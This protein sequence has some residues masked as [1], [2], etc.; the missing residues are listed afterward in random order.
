MKK[1]VPV[2]LAF[3]AISIALGVGVMSDSDAGQAPPPH[4]LHFVAPPTPPC[5]TIFFVQVGQPVSFPVVLMP[6]N[7]ADTAGMRGPGP[8]VPGAT[9][10]PPT[11][12]LGNPVVSTFT[13]TPVAEG[14]YAAHYIG[15]LVGYP[16]RAFCN[17]SFEV[18]PPAGPH[19]SYTQGGWGATPH[20]HNAASILANNFATVY[21]SGVEVGILGTGGFS[22]IFTSANAV[23]NYLPAGGTPGALDADSANPA[24][25]NH[26]GVFGGQVLAL[27]INVDFSAAGVTQNGGGAFGSVRICSSGNLELDGSTVAQVLQAANTALGGGPLPYGLAWISELND[28]VT[29]L[30]ESFDNCQTSNWGSLHLC[31]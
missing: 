18:L 2:S 14:S 28:L 7:P 24:S 13:W 20:G 3:F 26:S 23:K 22:M 21:P 4:T 15:A 25:D 19:C 1:I 16:A 30:N 6:D 12:L 5:G 29:A 11:P 10:T 9:M 27:K 8:G 31:Q 17:Y